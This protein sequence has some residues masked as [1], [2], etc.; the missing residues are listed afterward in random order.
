MKIKLFY[1]IVALFVFTD[2][3]SQCMVSEYKVTTDGRNAPA[4]I[5]ISKVE[6]RIKSY[7]DSDY[8]WITSFGII[9]DFV[10]KHT[11]SIHTYIDKAAKKMIQFEDGELE[12][13]YIL[14]T[15]T[16]I[17]LSSTQPKAGYI[18]DIYILKDHPNIR[19]YASKQLDKNVNPGIDYHV[20][21]GNIGGI[22]AI[23]M[24][25]KD[26]TLHYEL[27]SAKPVV[28]LSDKMKPYALL[29]KT[30]TAVTAK[31]ILLY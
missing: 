27:L 15:D 23:E 22:V 25:L 18:C 24:V 10:V 26:R 28:P 9:P 17:S 2:I 6:L 30:N 20:S 5:D 11:D 12:S 21:V 13:C 31:S 29:M 7:C 16:L 3:Y 14:K 1:N 8:I 19:I 4:F